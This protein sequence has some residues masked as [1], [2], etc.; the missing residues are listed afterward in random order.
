MDDKKS[1]IKRVFTFR[2]INVL[3]YIA[4]ILILIFLFI[5]L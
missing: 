1:L 5:F 2:T 3:L 4:L